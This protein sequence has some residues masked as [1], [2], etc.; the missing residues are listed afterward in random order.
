VD[1]AAS[2]A[3]WDRRADRKICERS[4]STRTRDDCS[5]R[6]S[7]VVLTPRRW[8]Q[9]RGRHV[10]PTGRGHATYFASD[11][12]KRARSP[13]RARRNPLKPLRAGMPGDSG[14]LVVTRVRSTNKSAHE[15]AGAAGTRHSPR[16]LLG[17]EIQQCLGRLASRGRSRIRDYLNVIASVAKQS[18]LSFY[19]EVDCFAALAMT[20]S[21]PSVLFENRIG[22]SARNTNVP[23]SVVPTATPGRRV[24]PPGGGVTGSLWSCAVLSFNTRVDASLGLR[25]SRSK[26]TTTRRPP[27]SAQKIINS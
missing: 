23:H 22:R 14:V 1:A 8:R 12:G 20:A 26:A 18:I 24:A 19:R 17:R 13:R 4:T 25:Q 10:G 11:G 15:A 27:C 9:V 3:R 5:V 7:R 2:C 16:P 6:R 21:K